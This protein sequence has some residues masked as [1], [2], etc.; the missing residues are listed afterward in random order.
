MKEPVDEALVVIDAGDGDLPVFGLVE[1]RV[2]EVTLCR[3][4][5]NVDV[6]RVLS[7]EDAHSVEVLVDQVEAL[8]V[9][10]IGVVGLGTARSRHHRRWHFRWAS[11]GD[12]RRDHLQIVL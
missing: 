8:G 1:E 2:L 9:E 3:D 7:G 12:R 11:R 10:E 6:A 5:S 4:P